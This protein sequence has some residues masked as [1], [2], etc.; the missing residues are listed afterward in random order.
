MPHC[1]LHPGFIKPDRIFISINLKAFSTFAVFT[2]HKLRIFLRGLFAHKIVDD[3]KLTAR[4]VS[5][6]P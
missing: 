2:F 3:T 6:C 5:S 4:P 1:D